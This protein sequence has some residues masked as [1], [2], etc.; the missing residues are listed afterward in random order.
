MPHTYQNQ[1]QLSLEIR[2]K[3]EKKRST[4]SEQL[5]LEMETYCFSLREENENYLFAAIGQAEPDTGKVYT[6]V[7]GCLQ[8]T[9]NRGMKYMLNLY[10]YDT[11]SILLEPIN[12]RS[13]S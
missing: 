10:A 6:D 11:N 3:R 13:D 12:T 5:A 2:V 4:N 7:S 1:K 8:V 9:S